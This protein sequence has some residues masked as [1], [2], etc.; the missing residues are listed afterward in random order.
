MHKYN[1][2]RLKTCKIL[3]AERS[4]PRKKR[5]KSA[6]IPSRDLILVPNES[7][8][9]FPSYKHSLSWIE[10]VFSEICGPN[11]EFFQ[12]FFVRPEKTFKTYLVSEFSRQDGHFGLPEFRIFDR[13]IVGFDNLNIFHGQSCALQWRAHPKK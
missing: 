13:S 7:P 1:S 11:S 3:P 8:D 12:T 5:P 4:S 2:C 6:N 9:R 10:S